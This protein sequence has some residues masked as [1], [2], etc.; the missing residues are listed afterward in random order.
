M[1]YN[2]HS[3][4]VTHWN[5]SDRH[6]I[7][8]NR[9]NHSDNSAGILRQLLGTRFYMAD[10]TNPHGFPCRL[11]IATACRNLG[12][13]IFSSRTDPSLVILN[14]SDL[15]IFEVYLQHKV[16]RKWEQCQMRLDHSGILDT[17]LGLVVHNLVGFLVGRYHCS[18]THN[19]I[20]DLQDLVLS[21][22][23]QYPKIGYK[24]W[25]MRKRNEYNRKYNRKKFCLAG[26][27]KKG[28]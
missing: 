15:E 7:P 9:H 12:H 5:K 24:I 14:V 10:N 11:N 23:S 27:L 20:L 16:S 28:P 1:S 13:T 21:T 18:I 2:L 3:P 17:M 8:H 26:K 6:K 4:L 22:S 25:T 19:L